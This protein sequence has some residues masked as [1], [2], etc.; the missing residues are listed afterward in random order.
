MAGAM[1]SGGARAE[2]TDECLLPAAILAQD[3]VTLR[4]RPL[5]KVLGESCLWTT[6]FSWWAPQPGVGRRVSLLTSQ[7]VCT[8]GDR[9]LNHGPKAP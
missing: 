8:M 1:L 7:T 2:A 5:K 6:P 9:L 4:V 3:L